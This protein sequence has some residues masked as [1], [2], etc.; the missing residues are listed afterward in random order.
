MCLLC[1]QQLVRI[2][3]QFGGIKALRLAEGSGSN[4][5]RAWVEFDSVEA[6]NKAKSAGNLVRTQW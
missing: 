3:A 2:F 5:R 1:E 6:A 4:A